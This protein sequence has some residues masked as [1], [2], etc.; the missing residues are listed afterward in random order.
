MFRN[1]KIVLWWTLVIL[2]VAG[3]LVYFTLRT[4]TYAGTEMTFKLK[5]GWCMDI[6]AKSPIRFSAA[7]SRYFRIVQGETQMFG[8][9]ETPPL[10]YQGD[11]Y[12][13]LEGKI[14]KGRWKVADGSS[15]SLKLVAEEP[16]TV[17][18][19]P[20]VVTAFLDTLLVLLIGCLVWIVVFMIIAY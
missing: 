7:D 19:F 20:T 2:A 11:D 14:Q 16:F 13:F 1:K 5:S 15:I 18:Y 12:F 8:V 9:P 17:S 10:D 3:V 4:R 6:A